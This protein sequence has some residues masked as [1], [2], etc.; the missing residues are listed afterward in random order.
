MRSSIALLL[1]FGMASYRYAHAFVPAK[2]GRAHKSI[3]SHRQNW[4][5][6]LWDEI[7]EF[8]TYGPGERKLLKERRL[9]KAPKDDVSVASFNKARDK[10]SFEPSAYDAPQEDISEGL[11]LQ[12]FQAAIASKTDDRLSTR[13]FDGYALK[14]MLVDL[15]GAPLDVGF[16]R[17]PR[18]IHCTIFPVALGNWK[19]QHTSEIDY[20]MHLQG[21]IEILDKYDNLDQFINFLLTT[22]STPKPGTSGVR[23]RLNL[24]EGQLNSI[25][26]SDK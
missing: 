17:Q 14:D 15:W 21:V 23:F 25:L 8:S 19:C 13:D 9:Q 16:E 1:L 4:V 26:K 2:P 7:V 22:D 10:K 18:M 12:A 11:S 6:D 20:L 24:T 5:G 3:R